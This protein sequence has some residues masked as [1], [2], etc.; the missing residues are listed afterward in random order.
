MEFDTGFDAQSA[1]L[2][3]EAGGG[4]G[5]GCEVGGSALDVE[6]GGTV[7]AGVKACTAGRSDE[8]VS[9]GGFQVDA[10]R[11]AGVLRGG[12]RVKAWRDDAVA[13]ALGCDGK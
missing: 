4:G 11:G 5:L 6:L 2:F 3:V 13:E 1:G 9:A 7:V 10:D 12:A 8:D